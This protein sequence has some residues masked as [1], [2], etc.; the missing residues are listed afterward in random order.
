M[1][2]SNFPAFL[3]LLPPPLGYG[4]VP[5]ESGK[6]N[7]IIQC[8]NIR[9]HASDDFSGGK[10]Y[11]PE[12]MWVIFHSICGTNDRKVNQCEEVKNIIKQLKLKY[13]GLGRN[14]T[15]DRLCGVR[16]Y[17]KELTVSKYLCAMQIYKNWRTAKGKKLQN[18]KLVQDNP[19]DIQKI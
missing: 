2:T 10:V 3:T 12:V 11:F 19:L 1:K 5:I 6:L 13:K 4:G 8:M 14:V 16:Y 9:S 15:P 7:K 17:K 18:N